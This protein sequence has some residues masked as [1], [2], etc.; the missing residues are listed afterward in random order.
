[1]SGTDGGTFN[2]QRIAVELTRV[3]TDFGIS[4]DKIKLFIVG[5]ARVNAV[6]TDAVNEASA[7]VE[8]GTTGYAGGN[9]QP[10]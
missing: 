3:M 4:P 2:G 5:G 7:P 10:K 9:P 1:M 8:P 6:A